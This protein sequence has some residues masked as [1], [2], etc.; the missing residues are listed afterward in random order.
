VAAGATFMPAM[1]ASAGSWTHAGRQSGRRNSE[2]PMRRGFVRGWSRIQ[3]IDN[4][5]GHGALIC[6]VRRHFTR[7]LLIYKEK[8]RKNVVELTDSGDRKQP[9]A[10][11]H[12]KPHPSMAYKG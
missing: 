11:N 6:M 1:T 7:K 4:E 2:N 12:V 10:K 9:R 8:S 5:I 3:A